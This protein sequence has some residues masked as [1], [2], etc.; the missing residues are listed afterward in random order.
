VTVW[1]LN[2]AP[3]DKVVP[4]VADQLSKLGYKTN[5]KLLA[6]G[7]YFTT[8]GNQATKAQIMYTDWYQD[9]PHPLDWF[10]VL[11]NGQRITQTHNNNY[12]NANFPEVNSQI[13]KLKKVIKL[14]PTINSEWAKV[15]QELVVKHAAAAPYLNAVQTD[16]F[17][18]K[19]DTSCY[20]N[21]VLF[22]FD[23][24]KICMK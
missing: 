11:F 24:T 20:L 2:E 10:D 8:I 18:P 4:Y 9:Y 14:T 5:I 19:V 21:H 1:G 13:A 3:S 15:D 6:H 23:W 22:M 7:V 16:F 12:S 17:G